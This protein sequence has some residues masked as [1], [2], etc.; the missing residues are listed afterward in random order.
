MPRN[1]STRV[2]GP[3]HHQGDYLEAVIDRWSR[4]IVLAGAAAGYIGVAVLWL[5][6]RAA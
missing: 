4:A 5:M 2:Y 3:G 6:S 1:D